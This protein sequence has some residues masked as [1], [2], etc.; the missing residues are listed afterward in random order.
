MPYHYRITTDGTAFTTR[1][2]IREADFRTAAGDRPPDR[3]ADAAALF[4][5]RADFGHV[6][7]IASAEAATGFPP[8]V[9]VWRISEETGRVEGWRVGG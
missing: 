6:E 9:S 2:P 8:G 3:T 5:D 4:R 1:E 7:R